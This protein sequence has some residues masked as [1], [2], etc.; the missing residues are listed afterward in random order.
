MRSRAASRRAAAPGWTRDAGCG[1]GEGDDAG[2]LFGEQAVVGGGAFAVDA[3]G[4]ELGV[5][6]VG[7]GGE[8]EGE[9]FGE[10]AGEG[11]AGGAEGGE[12]GPDVVA[13]EVVF[14]VVAEVLE[15]GGEGAEDDATGGGVE[16]GLVLTEPA[17]PVEHAHRGGVGLPAD[18][19]AVVGDPVLD[20]GAGAGER[21][22]G[23]PAVVVEGVEIE[24]VGVG[25]PAVEGG[26]V[27]AE[28]EQRDAVGRVLAL[29]G[30]R[31][32]RGGDALHALAGGRAGAPGGAA[33]AA[34][35]LVDHL[36]RGQVDERAQPGPGGHMVMAFWSCP[37]GHVPS[38]MSWC[39]GGRRCRRP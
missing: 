13:V 1:G 9:W 33:Q 6:E 4:V 22:A 19:F 36:A 18:A 3:V 35:A 26:V 5:D 34:E 16:V 31:R 20:G 14:D 11:E 17:E 12:V 21:G 32:Q 27:G 10:G 29:G 7:E 24:R 2:E 15:L 28:A 8:A 37:L 30:G 39:S 23:E 38:L 25:L